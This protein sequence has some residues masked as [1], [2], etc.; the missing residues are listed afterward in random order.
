LY[1]RNSSYFCTVYCVFCKLN[2]IIIQQ[3]SMKVTVFLRSPYVSELSSLHFCLIVHNITYFPNSTISSLFYVTSNDVMN[4]VLQTVKDVQ[5][6]CRGLIRPFTAVIFWR[7]ESK[8]LKISVGLFSGHVP[9]ILGLIRLELSCDLGKCKFVRLVI[10]LCI[11]CSS[12][13]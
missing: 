1:T 4:K 8:L 13:L 9:K 6:R 12:G 7:S 3:N 10:L 11:F 2:F 5:E